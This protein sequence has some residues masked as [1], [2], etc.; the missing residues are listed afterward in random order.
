M[1]ELHRSIVLHQQ[2]EAMVVWV[3]LE[4]KKQFYVEEISCIVFS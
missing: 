1:E 4:G 3:I 2:E